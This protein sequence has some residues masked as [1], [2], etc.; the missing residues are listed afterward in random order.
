MAT[1]VFLISFVVTITSYHGGT[2][3]AAKFNG[4]TRGK[5]SVCRDLT[6]VAY[7]HVLKAHH[8]S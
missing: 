1:T 8:F 3:S 7:F 6:V 2:Q 4:Q 5:G